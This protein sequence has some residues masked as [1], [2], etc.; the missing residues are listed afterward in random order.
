MI[1]DVCLQNIRF[2]TF[3]NI[4]LYVKYKLKNLHMF[5]KNSLKRITRVLDRLTRFL[6]IFY[7]A[8]ANVISGSWF[9]LMNII[10]AF[11]IAID[12]ILRDK[13]FL[14]SLQKIL[15]IISSAEKLYC[16]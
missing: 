4:N 7:K 14:P 1:A 11:S 2:K 8:S 13:F 5:K 16:A 10:M 6:F 9:I 12:A 15:H 3:A